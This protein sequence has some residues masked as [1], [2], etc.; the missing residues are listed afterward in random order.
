MKGFHSEG[1]RK[2]FLPSQEGPIQLMTK[3]LAPALG[4]DSE[5]MMLNFVRWTSQRDAQ[6]GS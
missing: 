4:L 3:G 5:D 2:F 1:G 6:R